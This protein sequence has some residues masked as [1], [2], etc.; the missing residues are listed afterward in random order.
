[1]GTGEKSRYDKTPMK[2]I[3]FVYIMSDGYNRYVI[4]SSD[5]A[6]SFLIAE[7]CA[8]IR[9]LHGTVYRLSCSMFL[10]VESLSFNGKDF[11]LSRRWER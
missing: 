5:E 11:N 4:L 10:F 9:A 6:A 8:C 7:E 1:M 3:V 2:N